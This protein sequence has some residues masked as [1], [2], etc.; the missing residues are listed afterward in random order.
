MQFSFL[1]ITCFISKGI[2]E[3]VLLFCGKCICNF[4]LLLQ[5]S[6]AL[7][8]QKIIRKSAIRV[9]R[10]LLVKHEFDDRYATEV[11][12]TEYYSIISLF[13]MVWLNLIEYV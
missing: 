1:Y 10:N 11:H 9:I 3:Y 13:I 2:C 6:A 8:E 5:V 4:I 12:K 7:Y